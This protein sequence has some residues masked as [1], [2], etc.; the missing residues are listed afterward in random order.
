MKRI[1]I[2]ATA[3]M[4]ISSLSHAG[5]GYLNLRKAEEAK[6]AAPVAVQSDADRQAADQRAGEAIKANRDNYRNH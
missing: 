1:I 4:A 6:N 3:L 2:A 5:E